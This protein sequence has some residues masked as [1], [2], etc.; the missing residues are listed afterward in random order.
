MAP[1]RR[2][3]R[4]S[5]ASWVKQRNPTGLRPR[6]AYHADRSLRNASCA[7]HLTGWDMQHRPGPSPYHRSQKFGP[8]ARRTFSDASFGGRVAAQ[9]PAPTDD[10]P[11]DARAAARRRSRAPYRSPWGVA[12]DPP[13]C[14]HV[15]GPGPGAYATADAWRRPASAAAPS[16]GSATRRGPCVS[17]VGP[18]VSAVG[19]GGSWGLGFGAP[20]AQAFTPAPGLVEV[21]RRRALAGAAPFRSGTRR[22]AGLTADSSYLSGMG[23][24]RPPRPRPATAPALVEA[25]QREAAGPRAGAPERATSRVLGDGFAKGPTTLRPARVDPATL[26]RLAAVE[27]AA[28][29]AIPRRKRG[30]E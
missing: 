6:T 7:S 5:F 9:R 16:F 27:A 24:P 25:V 13:G 15:A 1:P 22:L 11:Y 12:V 26:S 18:C 8:D 23:G 28:R 19:P 10:E 21:P 2:R 14:V 3:P 4:A 30:S 17:A 20:R 29:A